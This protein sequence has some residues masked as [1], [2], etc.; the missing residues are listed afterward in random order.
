MSPRSEGTAG[1]AQ[2]AA[3]ALAWSP[4]DATARETLARVADALVCAAS[5][6]G[7]SESPCGE[8][9]ARAASTRFATCAVSRQWRDWVDEM[10]EKCCCEQTAP[11]SSCG[12]FGANALMIPLYPL[13]HGEELAESILGIFKQKK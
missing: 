7:D 11:K 3:L 10:L 8:V 12:R 4:L 1:D 9:R 13:Q 6:R 5:S 2:F